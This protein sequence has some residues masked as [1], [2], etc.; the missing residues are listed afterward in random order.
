MPPIDI[1]ELRQECQ[2]ILAYTEGLTT[3]ALQRDTSLGDAVF[4]RV[5]RLYD[6]ARAALNPRG[7]AT[8]SAPPAALVELITRTPLFSQIEPVGEPPQPG[9]SAFVHK[10]LLRAD[11][12]LL[13]SELAVAQAK[14]T[15]L[16]TPGPRAGRV[17][18]HTPDAPPAA[19]PAPLH[20]RVVPPPPPPEDENMTFLGLAKK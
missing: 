3:D 7:A 13:R 5:Q 8:P 9:E 15:E 11:I 17:K 20:L 16:E 4:L 19:G 1:K 14:I 12:D 2:R 6:L 18:K 10:D